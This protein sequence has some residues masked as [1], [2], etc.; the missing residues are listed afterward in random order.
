MIQSCFIDSNIF[1]YAQG[2][3]ASYKKASLE[4]LA[5]VHS[6]YK[7]FVSTEILQEIAYRYNALNKRQTALEM[8]R[9][10]LESGIDILPVGRNDIQLSIKLLHQ[11]KQLP[12]R[13]AIHAAVMMN[14]RIAI[15]V[16][17]DTHFKGI[18]GIQKLSATEAKLL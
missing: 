6:H 15:I 3:E 2:K 9:D 1:M 17:E 4:F 5:T 11:H 14:H 8:V 18:R 12:V 16:T 13:D 7:P 10:I